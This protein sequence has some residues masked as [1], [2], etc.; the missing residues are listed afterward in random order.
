MESNKLN[1]A[2]NNAI[3]TTIELNK[4]SP[5]MYNA[6]HTTLVDVRCYAPTART[7]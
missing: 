3:H 5:A 4:L 2:L 7:T 6:I 1:S